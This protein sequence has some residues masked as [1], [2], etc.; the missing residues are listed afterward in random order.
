MLLN[1]DRTVYLAYAVSD[2]VYTV[3]ELT[4]EL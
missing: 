1:E 2:V 3:R 4:L